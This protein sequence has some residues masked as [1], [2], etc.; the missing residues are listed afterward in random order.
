MQASDIMTTKLVTAT[1]DTQIDEIANLMMEHNVSGVPIVDDGGAVV[2]IVS[3]GD[4]LRRVEG[5]ADRPRGRLARL[6]LIEWPS[7]TDFIQQRGRRARD[8]M[9]RNVVS[10]TLDMS[11]GEI[12][13]LL[14]REHVKRVPV[15]DGGRLIGIVS[16]ANLLHALTR[17]P[18]HPV[19][20]DA[21]DSALRT[22]LLE[23]I[24]KVT[25]ILMAH[26]QV[27]VQGGKAAVRGLVASQNQVQA[28]RVAA[29]TVEGLDEL[30]IELGT[31]PDWVWGI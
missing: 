17:A 1:P 5:A 28:A 22:A 18:A 16:R 20:T 9:T 4:L 27:T 31:A 13:R 12:A 29:E 15:V 8:I 6:F 3:E 25:G 19:P 7:T 14:E 26:I 24:G 23:E 2:G 10:V 21:D 11:V 30:D